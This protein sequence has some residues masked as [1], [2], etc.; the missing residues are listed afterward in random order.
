MSTGRI[1]AKQLWTPWQYLPGSVTFARFEALRICFK[2]GVGHG[3]SF[4][5]AVGSFWF[6]AHCLLLSGA[7]ISV[8]NFCEGA[9]IATRCNGFIHE[10]VVPYSAKRWDTTVVTP[11]RIVT[12]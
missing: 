4:R 5:K 3:D 10:K 6:V 7:S 2:I 12:P 1:L 9:A 8:I 11:S